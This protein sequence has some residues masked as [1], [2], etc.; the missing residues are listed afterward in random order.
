[1]SLGNSICSEF[2]PCFFD[3]CLDLTL[4]F[5]NYA[6]SRKLQNVASNSLCPEPLIYSLC[7]SPDFLRLK[8]N[9]S[10]NAILSEE[11]KK[12]PPLSKPILCVKQHFFL[13]F[14][15]TVRWFPNSIQKQ[16]CIGHASI[17]L[18]KVK[19]KLHNRPVATSQYEINRMLYTSRKMERIFQNGESRLQGLMRQD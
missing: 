1:M 6:I 4:K 2:L 11:H 10:S 12:K 8:K 17:K 3:L 14:T 5:A 7:S 19:K 18:K 13:L 15:Y 9:I 16:D